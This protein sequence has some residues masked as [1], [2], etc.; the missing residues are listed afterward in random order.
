VDRKI[1]NPKC[2]SCGYAMWL[3][4]TVYGA[5]P[6]QDQHVFQCPYCKLT[7]LTDD[8]TPVNGHVPSR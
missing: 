1:F 3:S 5:H 4:R 7:Y 2:P 6:A 8:H